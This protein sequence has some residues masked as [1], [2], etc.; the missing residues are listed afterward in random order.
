MQ[1]LGKPWSLLRRCI[2]SGEQYPVPGCQPA[3]AW[4]GELPSLGCACRPNL[5][6]RQ[7]LAAPP[8]ACPLGVFSQGRGKEPEGGTDPEEGISTCSGVGTT[9]HPAATPLTLLLGNHCTNSSDCC[10]LTPGPRML[11]LTCVLQSSGS[12]QSYTVA[13]LG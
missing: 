8:L 12:Y 1:D 11:Q 10:E 9:S 6:S 13:S 4:M 7:G 3:L 5:P 2:M